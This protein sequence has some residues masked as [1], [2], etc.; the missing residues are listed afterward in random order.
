MQGAVVYATSNTDSD[1]QH[2]CAVGLLKGVL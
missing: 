2:V 1:R